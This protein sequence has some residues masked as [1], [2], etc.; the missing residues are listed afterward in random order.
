MQLTLRGY[1]FTGR[2]REGDAL[3][4]EWSNGVRWVREPDPGSDIM[5]L[6][7]IASC[8]KE[9]AGLQPFCV[10]IS[11]QSAPFPCTQ[12]EPVE[13]TGRVTRTNGGAVGYRS[14]NLSSNSISSLNAR[15]TSNSISK[16]TSNS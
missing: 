4:L 9:V 1:D 12:K 15:S 6:M 11:R 16:A 5:A 14:G 13:K 3:E 8:G 2:V 7:C 10:S